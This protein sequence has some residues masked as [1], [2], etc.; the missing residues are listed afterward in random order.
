MRNYILRVTGDHSII[1]FF[2]QALALS[3]LSNFPT[4]FGSIL[5]P[6]AYRSIFKYMGSSCFIE[7]NVRFYAPQRI[8]I[9]HRVFIG[10]NSF[11]DAGPPGTEIYIG[12]DVHISQ[13]VVIRGLGKKIVINKDVNIGSHSTL[14]GADD[15][16]IG[17][18]C[19]LGNHVQL[20]SGDHCFEDPNTPIKMQGTKIGKIIIEDD[21]WIGALV[22]VLRGKT[23]GK[24]S[25]I[26]ANAVVTKNIPPYSIAVG[27][28]AKVICKRI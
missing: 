26:G 22:T 17:R 2:K 24:G 16:I 8:H 14:Y 10:E 6:T 19:L 18:Y 7:K 27:N 11:I 4:V 21:V 15:I 20:I 12:D 23:I 28:P 9:G 5:R 3:L 1:R 13:G 25:V